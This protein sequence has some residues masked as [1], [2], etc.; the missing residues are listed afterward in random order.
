MA[1]LELTKEQ[2]FDLVLQL[3]TAQKREMLRMLAANGSADRV[4]RQDFAEAQLRR[5]CAARGL[6]WDALSPD[7]REELI[8][9]LI[10]EDRP[11][12]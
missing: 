1:V 5:L 12:A 2:I 6:N 9:D 4:K 7:E 8:D 11:C 3:P 10:H